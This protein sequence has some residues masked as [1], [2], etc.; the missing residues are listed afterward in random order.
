[1]THVF[2]VWVCCPLRFNIAILHKVTKVI[3]SHILLPKTLPSSLDLSLNLY[4][5][6]EVEIHVHLPSSSP[7]KPVSATMGRLVQNLN[8][9]EQSGRNG[10]SVFK[11]HNCLMRPILSDHT[12][13]C[14]QKGRIWDSRIPTFTDRIHFY[15]IQPV[16]KPKTLADINKPLNHHI[17]PLPKCLL[18]YWRS[19]SIECHVWEKRGSNAFLKR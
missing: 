18:D 19:S 7:A 17:E 14:L 9:A 8:T 1:M 13:L 4:S 6:D 10:N 3:Q 12:I 16:K 11:L 5:I 15:S 2:S